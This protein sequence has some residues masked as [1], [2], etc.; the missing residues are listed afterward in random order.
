MQLDAA[1]IPT[2]EV[3]CEERSVSKDE[4]TTATAFLRTLL[5]PQIDRRIEHRNGR[6]SPLTLVDE[7]LDF[8]ASERHAF[9]SG[10]DAGGRGATRSRS[11]PG[12]VFAW[13]AP[14]PR[15]VPHR[16]G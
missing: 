12:F 4:V 13:N 11:W 14:I 15:V 7:L 3:S 16:S 1:T 10:P 2:I 5:R 6:G 9:A 8:Q